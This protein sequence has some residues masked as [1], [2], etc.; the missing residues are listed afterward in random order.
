MPAVP[1]S[2]ASLLANCQSKV[3]SG[4]TRA[5][6][7]WLIAATVAA[8]SLLCGSARAHVTFAAPTDGAALTAGSVVEVRWVDT[9][10]HD[11]VAYHLELRRGSEAPGTTIAELPASEHSLN[12]EV[13]RDPCSDCLLFIVQPIPFA[14]RPR[15]TPASLLAARAFTSLSRKL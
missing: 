3:M 6:L 7:N 8:A 1:D 4:K 13:P 9:I 15:T 2:F 11:T 14:E 10:T 5:Q 12:W